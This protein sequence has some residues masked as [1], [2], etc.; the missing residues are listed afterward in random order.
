MPVMIGAEM[1]TEMARWELAVAGHFHRPGGVFEFGKIT[2]HSSYHYCGFMIYCASH[3]EN[4]EKKSLLSLV[5]I[6]WSYY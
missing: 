2:T 4:L 1:R 6:K 3:Q 5:R